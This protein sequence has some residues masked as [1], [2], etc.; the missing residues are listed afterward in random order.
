MKWHSLTDCRSFSNDF[1][2][3]KMKKD[4]LWK[5]AVL[6]KGKMT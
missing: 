6:F 2:Q 5:R 4:N 3:T 1:N